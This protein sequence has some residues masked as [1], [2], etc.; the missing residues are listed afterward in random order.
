[1][2]F[3]PTSIEGACWIEPEKR[4]DERG[5]FARSFCEWEFEDHGFNP[6]VSQ[7]NISG[8]HLA[9]TLRGLHTQL[10]PFQE[11][12]LVRCTR[13]ELYDVILDLRK[14]SS[15]YLQ[16]F[17]LK[18]TADNYRMIYV[19]EGVYHGF[20]TVKDDTEVFYQ[21]SQEYVAEAGHG[22]RWNDPAFGIEWPGEVRIINE[23][24]ANYPDYL[25]A[26]ENGS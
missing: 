8:N 16:H 6:K 10:P 5:F 26:G 22:V 4:E 9:G 24:D 11:T 23:R 7:C 14:E 3:H 19:P 25:P 20:L 2:I 1:M 15:T 13:G 17:G 12:K 18:M 21:I